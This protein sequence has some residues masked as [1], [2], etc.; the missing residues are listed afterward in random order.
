MKLADSTVLVTGAYGG[1]GAAI[2]RELARRSAALVLTGRDADRLASLA[3]ELRALGAQVRCIACD[4]ADPGEA[5]ALITEALRQAGSIDAVVNCAGIQQ[6]GFF[7]EE[8]ASDTERQFQ[9]NTVAPIALI[10][11]VLPHMLKRRSGLVVNVGSIFGSIAFP[12]FATYSAS[13]FALRGFSE[14]L[15]RELAG[16]GVTVTYVAPRFTRTPFNGAAATRMAEALGMAQDEPASVALSVVDEMARGGADR[17]LGWPEKFFVRLNA[18]FPRLV[19]K[20]LTR[21]RDQMRPYA[22]SATN[23]TNPTKAREHAL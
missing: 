5:K 13:K 11:A 1:I 3:T 18:L 16:S 14:A 17:Y 8:A 22:T 19:D 4:L 23:A 15:R 12:C 2:A 9:V 6:F 21:Q 10:A 20:A 7:S